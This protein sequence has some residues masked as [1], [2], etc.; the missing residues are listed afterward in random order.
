MANAYSASDSRLKAIGF[1][2]LLVVLAAGCQGRPIPM[3]AARGTTAL[4]P[5]GGGGNAT[6]EGQW[7]GYGTANVEDRQRGRLRIFLD[8]DPDVELTVRGVA[9]VSADR[10]SPAGL[11]VGADYGLGDQV[12]AMVDIPTN[13]PLGDFYLYALR[14]TY[15]WNGSAWVEQELVGQGPDYQGSLEILP[16]VRSPTPLEAH[17]LGTWHDIT[18]SIPDFVPHPK[19][20]FVVQS[21]PTLL[22][23]TQFTVTYPSSRVLIH[24][25]VAEPIAQDDVD[26][27]KSALISYTQPSADVID[28]QAVAPTGAARPAFAIIFTL[29]RPNDPPASGGGPVTV[30]DFTFSDVQA[31][32][33]S[34]V[35]VTP[36]VP[37]ASK[38]I[39]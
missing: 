18:A 19:L 5:I 15:Q 22:G 25:V 6:G 2:G 30:S 4:I 36:T 39:F 38:K 3:A 32:D 35:A 13:A 14:Y 17:L 11:S 24:G 27:G 12:V 34:G 31:W 20:R 16:E 28:V 33:V 10:A 1:L 9:R 26:W 29:I 8:S 7:M 21:G 37:A 23:A